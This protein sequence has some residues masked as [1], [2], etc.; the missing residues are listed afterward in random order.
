MTRYEQ[1]STPSRSLWRLKRIPIPGNHIIN[2]SFVFFVAL[3]TLIAVPSLLSRPLSFSL[4]SLS[5]YP[6][7]VCMCLCRHQLVPGGVRGG[8][9]PRRLHLE[10]NVVRAK[11]R[12]STKYISVPLRAHA[13]HPANGS[14]RGSIRRVEATRCA[15]RC[16]VR[17][18]ALVS[19]KITGS[20]SY[21]SLQAR[22]FPESARRTRSR[23]AKGEGVN[24]FPA[25]TSISRRETPVFESPFISSSLLSSC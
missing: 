24:L 9:L 6:D 25:F 4:P 7:Y 11:A 21:A 1:G 2:N 8:A 10:R 17:V 22:H 5:S 23:F 20:T 3:M 13:F 15:A 19:C 14:A 12:G 16:V 18:A